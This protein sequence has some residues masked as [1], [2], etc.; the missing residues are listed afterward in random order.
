MNA[1]KVVRSVD[2]RVGEESSWTVIEESRIDD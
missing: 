2:L 1:R